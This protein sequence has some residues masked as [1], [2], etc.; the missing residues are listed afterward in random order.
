METDKLEFDFVINLHELLD[1]KNGDAVKEDMRRVVET[2]REREHGNHITI[3]CILEVCYLTDAE[4]E[5]LC[6]WCL[7]L[8]IDFVKTSTGFG[9]GDIDMHKIRVMKESVGDEA[10]IKAAGGIDTYEEFMEAIELGAHRIGASKGVKLVEMH[11][12]HKHMDMSDKQFASYIDHTFL[13]PDGE[14]NDIQ[15]IAKEV[16]EYG[17]AACVCR[18]EFVKDALVVLKDSD[19]KIGSCIGF[20][21]LVA[22]DKDGKTGFMR[23]NIPTEQKIAEIEK[24]FEALKGF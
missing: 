1:N 14:A 2:I 6:K 13:Y 7:E 15:Q 12:E 16:D 22:K 3:K 9:T 17:F 19:A 10:E 20:S 18:P 24:S 23:Y 5:L 11:K 4:I 21:G 8:G